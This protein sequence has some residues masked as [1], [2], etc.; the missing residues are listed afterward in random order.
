M[1]PNMPAIF[2]EYMNLERLRSGS[3]GFSVSEYQRWITL[4][5]IL[6]KHFQPSLMDADNDRRESVRVPARLRIG[7]ETYGEI[8][9]CLMTNLS[10][11][12][13][14]IATTDPLPLGTVM[15]LWVRIEESGQEIEVE[16]EVA[17][18]N[19]GPGLLTD[20]VGMGIK[21]VRMS[22]DQEKAVDNLYER[23]LRRAL[24]GV[25]L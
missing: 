13:L 18:Q 21:F 24:D 23:S 12:G 1:T 8:R 5:K 4:K 3:D 15:M 7:F 22:E 19:S 11:R 9:D 6:N 14:F 20:D 16:G 17:S 2:R 25:D 10:R